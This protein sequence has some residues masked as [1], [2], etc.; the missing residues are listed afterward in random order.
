MLPDVHTGL[1][2]RA[3]GARPAPLPATG[4]LLSGSVSVLFYYLSGPAFLDV[5]PRAAPDAQTTVRSLLSAPLTATA[6]GVL[7]V[8]PKWIALALA[9]ATAIALSQRAGVLHP[10]AGAAALIFISGGPAITDLG[11]MYLL[12]PLTAGNLLCCSMAA[13]INNLSSNRQYPLFFP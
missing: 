6:L 1:S 9:P 7:Q 8:L 11:W 12:L 5:L 4:G 10:P 13:L 3:P 2:R